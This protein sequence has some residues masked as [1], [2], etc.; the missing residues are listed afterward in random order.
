MEEIALPDGRRAQLWT[1][2]AAVG[3]AVLVC[4]GTPDTRWVARTGADGRR[5]RRRPAALREPAR[6][7]HLDPGPLDDVVG[8]RRRGR[9][10]RRAGARPGRRARHVGRRG[11]RRRAGRP[12]PGPGRRAG[13]GRGAP[14]DP[15]RDGPAGRRGRAGPARVRRVGGHAS[16][17]PTPT[18]PPW[19]PAGSAHCP[20][21]TPRCSAPRSR[22][23]EVAASVREALACHDGYLRDAALLVRPT[24]ASTLSDVRGAHPPLVRR[25]R[26]PQPARDR[27]V[28][29]RA[30]RR[31]R[32]HASPPRRTWPPCWR[33]GNRS[34]APS[35]RT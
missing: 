7:R 12:A 24:G 4:H 6:L 15:H 22:T 2:G 21:T 33:T 28:V 17:P 25:P 8:R 31:R 32:A 27:P 10:A 19:P 5:R 14:R 18:T 13:R 26:R 11:V 20:P 1:G 34:C 35:Q 3:P 23:A 29:G 9:R 30:H 16:T